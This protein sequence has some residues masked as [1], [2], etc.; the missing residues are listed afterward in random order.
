MSTAIT[1]SPGSLP[2]FS[3]NLIT[4]VESFPLP[5]RW[6]FVKVTSSSGHV[7]WGEATLEGHSDAILGALKD[8]EKRFIG[9]PV[10][11]IQDIWQTAYMGRFYRGGEVLMSALS[12]LDTALWDLR[13]STV[14]GYPVRFAERCPR[15]RSLVF[16]SGPCSVVWLETRSKS[17]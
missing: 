4:K 12:G 8:L 15:A 14:N 6:V 2:S 1:R 9:W 16:Q 13:V 17:M 3:Q 5:P 10:E 11:N 7:G